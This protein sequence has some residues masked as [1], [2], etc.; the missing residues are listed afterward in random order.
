[1]KNDK[2]TS[3]TA[4]QAKSNTPLLIIALV[5]VGALL[6]G[7][8][9]LSSSKTE[10]TVANGNTATRSPTP[11]RTPIPADAPKGADPP[12][13]SGSATAAVT[14]EE[15][16]DFQCG[17][18]AAVHPALNEIKSAYGSKIRFIFRNYPLS[19]HDKAD[20][21]ALAVEA[22]RMQSKFWDMQNML[23]ANQKGWMLK[24]DYKQI[25]KGY[26]QTIGMDAE[27]WERDMGGIAARARVN[28]DLDRGK[29]LGITGT[30]ALFVNGIPYNFSDMTLS[31]LRPIIDAEL[32]K[33]AG[34]SQPA[35]AATD[36]GNQSK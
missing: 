1:M 7:W 3:G 22:A 35:N 17:S 8:Y 25:W 13:E 32:Q 31:K 21:A 26:A 15:F 4:K 14:L 12:N 28:A 33:A 19:M 34:Q 16:A 9:M 23:F 5:L 11:A 30:P 20:D 36:T 18:C 24:D 6:F 10:P 29:A 2:E 27:K